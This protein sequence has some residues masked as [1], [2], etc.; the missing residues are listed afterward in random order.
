LN[1]RERLDY[2]FGDHPNDYITNKFGWL[3][4]VLLSDIRTLI[5]GGKRLKN[6]KSRTLKGFYGAGN[7][8]I[9]ILLCVGIEF[10]AAL[11]VGKTKYNVGGAYSAT[12]NVAEFINRFFPHH[13]KELPRIVWDGVRN[14]LDHTFIPKFLKVNR[15]RI[16]LM[17]YTEP[18]NIKSHLVKY[19]N[20]IKINI[21]CIEFYQEVKQVL[22]D[23]KSLLQSCKTRQINFMKAWKS[24]VKFHAMNAPMLVEFNYMSKQLRPTNRINLF[25]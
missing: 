13:A 16:Q 20:V 21:N 24:I 11:Y 15:K 2:I 9:P 22:K 4:T 17:F 8:T 14:S 5:A 19:R 7:V 12:D 23:Y 3:D 1:T 10:A 6:K 25:L 18:M